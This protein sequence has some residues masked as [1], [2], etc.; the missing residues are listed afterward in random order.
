MT[1]IFLSVGF[2]PNKHTKVT[3]HFLGLMISNRQ[4]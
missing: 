4:W 2:F 3:S 1:D